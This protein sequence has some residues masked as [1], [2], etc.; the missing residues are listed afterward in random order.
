MIYKVGPGKSY[1]RGFEC[2]TIAS[3]LL[4][5]PKPRQTK[6]LEGQAVNFDFGT[7]L[8]INN[9]SGSPSIGIN[10]STTV[11]LRANRVGVSSLNPSGKEIGVGRVYDYALEAGSYEASNY[12]LNKWDISLFDVQT[13]GDLQVNESVTLTVPTYIK[14]DSSGATAFLKN[15]VSAG[16]AL[17]VYQIS[18]NFINGEKL[19][20]DNTA[21]RRVSIGWTNYGMSDVQSLYGT[22]GD[23]TASGPGYG[24]TFSADII[25]K[26]SSELGIGSISGFTEAAGFIATFTSPSLTFPG[27]VTTGNL[28]QW[29]RPGYS[30]PIMAKVNIV[31]TNSLIIQGVT[32]VTGICEGLLSFNK[33]DV[34][35]FSIINTQLQ[36]TVNNERLFVP[37]PKKNVASADL[38]D[39]SLI[40]R[41]QWDNVTITISSD[42]K[43]STQTFQTSDKG[44]NLT[45]LPF[46]EERYV[47]TRSDGSTEPLTSD[48]FDFTNGSTALTINGLGAADTVGNARLIATLRKD[49]VTSKS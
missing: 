13:Y 33:E 44:T 12:E 7:T 4:D 47:L 32:T 42:G 40:V 1:V 30:V 49:K 19:V 15:D 8:R 6:L 45:F 16:T 26:V 5:V 31:N 41:E 23:I 10:T 48:M 21:E 22:V 18:G 46:D 38:T 20:F 9:V 27:I 39:S 28:V 35:D 24:T 2:E 43:G 17:T 36:K 3:T 29:S 11:S 37:L 25:P 34:T 14:G